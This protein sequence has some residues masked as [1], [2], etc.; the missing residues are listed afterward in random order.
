MKNTIIGI[1]IILFF[2]IITKPL[3]AQ[4]NRYT[5]NSNWKFI[6]QNISGAEHPDYNDK[7]WET[8][9]IPHTWNAQD[10]IDDIPGY[11]RG[12]A[13]YRKNIFIN[14]NATGKRI[15]LYFEGAN[16]ETDVFING[17]HAG[18]HLGGYTRFCFDITSYIHPG[19][20]NCFAIKVN[21]QHDTRIAPLN[22]DFTFFGGIYRDLYLIETAQTH[23]CTTD[24]ASSGV[25]IT[26]PIVNKKSAE[27]NI[28]T[29]ISNFEPSKISIRIEN[30]IFNHQ[31]KCINKSIQ[32]SKLS[33][34]GNTR[35]RAS[36]HIDRPDLWSPDSPT[37]YRVVTT[38]Y[39]DK[40]NKIL[41][42]IS[43][44]LG[45]R[46]FRFDTQ[47]GFFLNGK[48]LKLIGTNRHQDYKEWGNA[49]PDE[50]HI[51][52]IKLI[53]D[54]GGNFLRVSHYP[55]DPVIMEM[56]DK[57]GILTSVEIPTNNLITESDDFFH[58]SIENYKEMVRQ[59]FNSPSV[60]IWAYMNEVMIQYPYGNDLSHRTKYIQSMYNLAS[61][62]DSTLRK[63]DPS[64][65]TMIP[66]HGDYKPYEESGLTKIPMIHGWNL[67]AGWYFGTFKEFDTYIDEMHARYPNKPIFITEYG[68]DSDIRLH[69]L[70][71]ERFDYTQE[72]SNLYHEHYLKAIK[73]R[74]FIA[75][76]T[77]WNLNCFYSESRQNAIPHINGKGLVDT[78]RKLKDS[79]LF[80]KANL[81]PIPMTKIGGENWKI[82]GSILS[83]DICK[84]PVKVY[85]NGKSVE[86]IANGRSLGEK[87][88]IDGIASF[89]VPF[90]NG[91]NELYAIGENNTKDYQQIDFRGINEELSKNTDIPF[92][93]N[94]MLGSNRYFEDQELSQIWIPEKEY[95]KGSWGYIGGT[96]YRQS[97]NGNFTIGS[98]SNISG[99]TNDPIF[100]TQRIGIE[101]FKADVP[102]GNY[103]VYLYFAELEN[104]KQQQ[105]TA[106][107]NLGSDAIVLSTG[108]RVFDILING[109]S[110]S[111]HIN[112]ARNHGTAQA[113]IIKFIIETDHNEGIHIT[114]NAIQNNPILNAVRIYRNY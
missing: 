20:H 40:N 95:Q 71:P 28:E 68:A 24:Y 27:I 77:V 72:Y 41:D 105:K 35:I 15:Y 113:V 74:A 9:P 91:M 48:P 34:P 108:E 12:P 58:Y 30:T 16:Q 26:T 80:Y 22:A 111:D 11:Y 94:V 7:V 6:R 89:D 5:I 45:L 61:S 14:K 3:N 53:K 112:I 39:N 38:I 101:A 10:A 8:V 79:Y 2:L 70:S 57:L 33:K 82:R 4:R 104:D 17:K 99:T 109:K 110:V 106:F 31:G 114:F 52:D 86:L 50:M 88:T 98:Q 36:I 97:P 103:S 62:I 55:Q 107:Y 81:S 43:N 49:L 96:A 54:M 75:A 18:H 47:K 51:R 102:N 87:N 66:F 42:K 64:R 93:L 83:H 65:Y 25:Y 59:N 13:W 92:E 56:C 21:N 78:D 84:Q 23:V 29:L 63:E 69:S 100:Q 90:K 67:Y 76:A 32:K 73:E 19:Q 85:S 1:V 46:W 44:P 37:L 60:V